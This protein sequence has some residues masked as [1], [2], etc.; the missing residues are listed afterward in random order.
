MTRR[1]RRAGAC[2]FTVLELMIAIVIVAMIYALAVPVFPRLVA[3]TRLKA[4]ASELL[5]D[6]RAARG[7]AISQG[8]AIRLTLDADT[9]GGATGY[10][11][12]GDPRTLPWNCRLAV[13]PAPDALALLPPSLGADVAL[14]FFPDGSATGAT[15]RVSQGDRALRLTVDGLTGRTSLD[16]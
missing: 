9:G 8:R 3:G 7:A 12:E 5:H 1:A 10:A 16:E 6:L 14:A 13:A 4:V 11:V 15:L 2:G